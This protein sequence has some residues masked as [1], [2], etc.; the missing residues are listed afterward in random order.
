MSNKWM[1]AFA[2][3]YQPGELLPQIGLDDAAIAIQK[4]GVIHSPLPPKA[5]SSY[6][7]KYLSSIIGSFKENK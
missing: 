5:M 4:P 1:I 7:S 3:F 6:G 2:A